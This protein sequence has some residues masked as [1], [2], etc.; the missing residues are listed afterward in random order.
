[1]GI[2]WGGD[3]D[4]FTDPIMSMEATVKAAATGG[5]M[6]KG[7]EGWTAAQ[8]QVELDRARDLQRKAIDRRKNGHS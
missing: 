5:P 8:V 7:M 4:Y 2:D 3:P 6:P 1:M